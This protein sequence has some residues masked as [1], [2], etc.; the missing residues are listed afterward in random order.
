MKLVVVATVLVLGSGC[1]ALE[2]ARAKADA[3][4]EA[5]KAL[6]S[7]AHYFPDRTKS[8]PQQEMDRVIGN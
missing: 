7:N 2:S 6:D 8:L 1:A 4:P 3:D 5:Y